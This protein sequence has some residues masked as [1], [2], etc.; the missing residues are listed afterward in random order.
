MQNY[1]PNGP[2]NY[3]HPN[4]SQQ[5]IT[6]VNGKASVDMIQLPPNS[7]VLLL[8]T[9]APIV[10]M[11]ISDGVGRVTSIPYDVKLHEDTPTVDKA[12]ELEDRINKIES[13]LKDLRRNDNGKSNAQKSTTKSDGSKS[14]PN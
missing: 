10:W 13:V 5:Q 11:C 14:Q 4:M 2:Y 9:T 7:S 12:T 1:Y 3:S 6:Q 8:D